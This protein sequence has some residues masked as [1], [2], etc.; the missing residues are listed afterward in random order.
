MPAL[1]NYLA[2][3]RAAVASLLWSPHHSS[4]LYS[5]ADVANALNV[6]ANFSG[7]ASISTQIDVMLL[8][9][10]SANDFTDKFILT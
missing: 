1:P 10:V 7:S 2:V 9:R 4:S 5:P 6:A 8:L 3:V